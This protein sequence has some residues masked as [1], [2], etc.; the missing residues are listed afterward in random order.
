MDELV[1]DF[2][3]A[4]YDTGHYAGDGRSGTDL[5][6]ERIEERGRLS[7][8]LDARLTAADALAE[9]LVIIEELVDSYQDVYDDLVIWAYSLKEKLTLGDLRQIVASLHQYEEA[10]R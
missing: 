7:I 1:R 8:K 9:K 3:D 10:K 6:R 5:H 2:M 4:A